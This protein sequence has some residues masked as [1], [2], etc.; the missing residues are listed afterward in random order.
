M[1]GTPLDEWFRFDYAIDNWRAYDLVAD[2]HGGRSTRCSATRRSN[3]PPAGAGRR[4]PAA[5]LAPTAS[6]R[7]LYIHKIHDR[8]EINT[9][10]IIA[11]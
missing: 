4:R 1:Q 11:A 5:L 7:F 9:Q 2:E 10:Q 8:H 6:G 3:F